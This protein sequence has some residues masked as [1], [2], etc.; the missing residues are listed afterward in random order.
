MVVRLKFRNEFDGER[1]VFVEVKEKVCLLSLLMDKKVL[2]RIILE[3]DRTDEYLTEIK[4]A[5]S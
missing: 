1:I 5:D 4:D 2:T 3:H